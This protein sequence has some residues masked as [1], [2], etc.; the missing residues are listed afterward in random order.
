M[1]KVIDEISV[2]NTPTCGDSVRWIDWKKLLSPFFTIPSTFKKNSYHLFS[3][4]AECPGFVRGKNISSDDNW[5]GMRLLNYSVRVKTVKRN[6]T[7]ILGGQSVDF[8]GNIVRSNR[9]VVDMLPLLKTFVHGSSL[10]KK[11]IK[12]L[13]L[14]PDQTGNHKGPEVPKTFI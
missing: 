8:K 5:E 10:G 7:D 12:A 13:T 9:K 2:S 3:F 1:I 4:D 11:S 6:T 14:E